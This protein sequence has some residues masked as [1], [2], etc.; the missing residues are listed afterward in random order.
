MRFSNFLFLSFLSLFLVSLPFLST[1]GIDRKN[2]DVKFNPDPEQ[3]ETMVE[4]REPTF[5]FTLYNE[6]EKNGTA[7]AALEVRGFRFEFSYVLNSIFYLYS[8][9]ELK[10]ITTIHNRK[11]RLR[12][13]KDLSARYA[14]GNIKRGKF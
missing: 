14:R 8:E 13:P 9:L 10:N 11:L 5:T 3:E 6:D 2:D 4:E 12:F 7:S 1:A